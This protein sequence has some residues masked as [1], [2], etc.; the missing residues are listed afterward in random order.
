M[1]TTDGA[2]ALTIPVAFIKTCKKASLTE[3][4]TAQEH[5]IDLCSLFGHPTPSEEDP[6][7]ERFA[8]EKGAA[9]VD[10]GK[11]FVDVWKRDDFAWAYKRK[12]RNRDDALHQLIRYAPQSVSQRRQRRLAIGI[13]FIE[14][15]QRRD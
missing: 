11:G 12:K 4:R 1:R 6:I 9:K 2:R 3:C 7:G 5:I 10:G 13:A 14:R 15:P 8:F